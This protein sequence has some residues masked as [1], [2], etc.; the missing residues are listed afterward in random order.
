M[1]EGP[2]STSQPEGMSREAMGTSVSRSLCGPSLV[3]H[4]VRSAT[5]SN[6]ARVGDLQ[7]CVERRSDAGMRLE[8]V[9]EDGVH[10]Q[11]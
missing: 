4:G 3:E 5:G 10:N 6:T 8:A 2:F 1:V 11:L 7:N 9:T